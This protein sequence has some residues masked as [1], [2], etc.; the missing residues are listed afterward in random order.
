VGP[1]DI[2][3]RGFWVFVPRSYDPSKPHK[4]IY[5]GAGCDDPDIYDAGK[6]GFPYQSSPDFDAIM[7]GLD[8]DTHSDVPLCYDHQNPKSN[9]LAFFPW[10][11]AKIES[12]FCVD[13]SQEF[14]SGFSSGSVLAQQLDC[15]WP[16][17]LRGVASSRGFE[18]SQLP[19]CVPAPTALFHVHDYADTSNNYQAFIPG[20]SRVLRQ[21]GCSV[22][23]C[24]DPE[25]SVLTSP[26]TLPTGIAPPQG[27]ACRQFNGCPTAYP[28]VFCT[29]HLPLPDRYD[30]REW[31]V[32]AFWDFM[33]HLK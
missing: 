15:A 7:V 28:V 11:T 29:T 1:G 26:Y 14:F 18:P 3:E 6:D 33:N 25:S 8:Y 10:L 17:K 21:N 23:D 9:D 2:E 4:V 16:A 20:C 32:P 27:T 5:Q 22:T 19:S 13:R 24:S 12:T 30:M 31:L